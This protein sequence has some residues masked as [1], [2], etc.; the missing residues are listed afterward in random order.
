VRQVAQSLTAYKGTAAWASQAAVVQLG[1]SGWTEPTVV[2]GS[3]ER[4]SVTA[5]ARDH[6]VVG[7]RHALSA[8]APSGAL[9]AI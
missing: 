3:L 2:A 4:R 8:E 7:K 9:G 1:M 6:R 5:L